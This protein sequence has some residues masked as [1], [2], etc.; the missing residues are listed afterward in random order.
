MIHIQRRPLKTLDTFKITKYG[1]QRTVIQCLQNVF[2]PLSY[3]SSSC[4]AT[5]NLRKFRVICSVCFEVSVLAERA[6]H[7]HSMKLNFEPWTWTR[8]MPFWL[9]LCLWWLSFI[10]PE[11]KRGALL[12]FHMPPKCSSTHRHTGFYRDS[13]QLSNEIN[14]LD[15]LKII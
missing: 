9:C 4:F 2:T 15:V 3:V 5:S 10:L 11:S 6:P 12:K 7:T 13:L 14:Y 1:M 8:Q